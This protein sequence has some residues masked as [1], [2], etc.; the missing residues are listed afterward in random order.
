MINIL[1]RT[2]EDIAK[3]NDADLRTLMDLLC[4][5]EYRKYN[6]SANK[7]MWSGHQDA[8]DGGLDVIINDTDAQAVHDGFIPR[9]F[10]CFQ[11]RKHYVIILG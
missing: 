5:A 1:D 10:T 6:L 2:G 3:L 7:I 9:K 4:E 11:V 8:P